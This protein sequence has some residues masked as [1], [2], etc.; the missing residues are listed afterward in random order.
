MKKKIDQVSQD[1]LIKNGSI[2]SFFL[3]SLIVVEEFP[4]PG[5]HDEI[6]M[7]AQENSCVEAEDE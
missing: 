6:L 4:W 1:E 3:S 7:E 2:G 5:I